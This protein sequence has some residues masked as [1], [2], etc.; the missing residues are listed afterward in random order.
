MLIC[1]AGKNSIAVNALRFLI[2]KEIPIHN[3]CV[4]INATDDGLHGW[5]PSLK[6]YAE[7]FKIPIKTLQEL[8]KIKDLIFLSMEFD[9]LIK[10]NKF[11]SKKLYNIHFSKLPSYK[12]MYTS[13]WPILNG[14]TEMGVT[15]HIIDHGIDTG[16]I[17]DQIVFPLSFGENSYDLYCKFLNYA[18][19]IF[20]QNW[21]NL[22]TTD[23]KGELQAIIN[24]SYYSKDTL[25][26]RNIS[27]NLNATAYHLQN[28]IRAFNF[29]PYQLPKVKGYTIS[30]V[31]ITNER[32]SKKPGTLL[33]SNNISMTFATIDYNIILFKDNLDEI[34]CSAKNDNIVF[35]KEA[36]KLGYQLD[37]KNEKG[38]TPLMVASYNESYKVFN[39]LLNCNC[40]VNAINNNGTSVLMYALTSASKTSNL[41]FINSLLKAGACIKHTDYKGINV[42]EYAKLYGNKLVIST[43]DGFYE[44]K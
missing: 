6:K 19:I 29:R 1:I 18:F 14:E 39:Y 44:N 23:L 21:N 20:K 38:W 22:K 2:E 27:I 36:S 43:L 26:Y 41:H 35:I 30:H 11:K 28:Q 42:I 37:E 32:S 31:K 7:D 16:N 15:L 5:Q 33:N 4:C 34:I 13:V 12:G 8:Y 17:I 10:P 3:L 25:D 40:N 24:S 9:K